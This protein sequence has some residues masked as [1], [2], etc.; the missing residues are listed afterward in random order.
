MPRQQPARAG[1]RSCDGCLVQNWHISVLTADQLVWIRHSSSHDRPRSHPVSQHRLPCRR[2]KIRNRSS[3]KRRGKQGIIPLM[4]TISTLMARMIHP[5]SIRMAMPND[6]DFVLRTLV[7]GAGN[8][9][10]GVTRNSH[11]GHVKRRGMSVHFT[12]R[13]GARRPN[14]NYRG[15][16][17]RRRSAAPRW[18]G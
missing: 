4:L 7:T 11:V 3:Q 10:S 1:G 8:A 16:V 13:V 12:P 17:P 9:R 14:P 6:P 15:R 2:R 18:A 5:V